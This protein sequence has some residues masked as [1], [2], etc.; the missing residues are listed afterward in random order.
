[1]SER[2]QEINYLRRDSQFCFSVSIKYISIYNQF[3]KSQIGRFRSMS[4]SK[5]EVFNSSIFFVGSYIQYLPIGL[6]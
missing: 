2:V 6:S 3:S 1:M 4:V 5:K